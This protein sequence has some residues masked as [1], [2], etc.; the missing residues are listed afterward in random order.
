VGDSAFFRGIRS[1]YAKYRHATALTDD[2]RRE[3]ERASGQSLGWFFDQWLR[4]PGYAEVT[5]HWSYDAGQG[6]VLLDVEQGG[7]WPAYRF[8][9]AIDV[10]DADGRIRRTRVEVAAARTQRIA[11]PLRLPRAPQHV[12]LDPDVRLLARFTER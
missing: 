6:R 2:L 9:L 4:R 7:R 5:T 8:P 11:L 1:Y 12:T 3:M 10:R